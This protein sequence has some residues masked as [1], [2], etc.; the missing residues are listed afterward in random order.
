MGLKIQVGMIVPGRAG[1]I[2]VTE[3]ALVDELR[4]QP[5]VTVGV[6]EFGSRKE[7]ETTLER[8]ADRIRDLL[9]YDRLLRREQP[10]LVYI[11]TSLNKRALL[12]DIGYAFLSKIRGVPLVVK[13]HGCDAWI[14]EQKPMLW[15]TLTRLLVHWAAMVFLLSDEEVR[16]FRTADLPAE[17]IRLVKNMVSL[18]RFRS[19]GVTKFD[20]PGILFIARF[21]KEKGL[22]DLLKAGR[23]LLDSDRV[24]ALY[25]V[26]D[27]PIR[28]EAEALAV[29]LGLGEHVK[30][31]GLI[32]EDEA[33]EYYLRSTILALPTYFYEGFPMAILQG[34]AAGLPIVTTKIRAAADY[35]REP[36]NALWV[37][38]H[39]P[40][41]LAEAIGRILDWLPLASSMREN[42]LALARDFAVDVVTTEYLDAF[43][44]V[45]RKESV[46]HNT[47]VT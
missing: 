27:G 2:Y 47:K 44:D 21:I 7:D 17:K 38:S 33:T 40:E 37:Q 11:N 39:N 28:K 45:V 36:D 34:M 26:G 13:E 6:F 43:I 24:F 25:C 46:D 3:K 8:I 18:A 41:M 10:D 29:E 12:R 23:M 20:P 9:A 1:G 31:T 19:D 35:L 14:V 15:W 42:N 22:F 5:G 16:L 30:F 4:R 32:S